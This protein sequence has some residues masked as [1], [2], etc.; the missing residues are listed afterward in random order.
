MLSI[1]SCVCEPSDELKIELDS[2]EAKNNLYILEEQGRVEW[3]YPSIRIDFRLAVMNPDMWYFKQT[4]K[5]GHGTQ[6]RVP[7][8][9]HTQADV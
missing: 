1:F 9:A 3:P 6:Q 7:K 4:D 2:R 5:Q 8:L